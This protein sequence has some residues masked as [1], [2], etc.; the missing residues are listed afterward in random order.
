MVPYIAGS[1][2]PSHPSRGTWKPAC[3]ACDPSGAWLPPDVRT[4][5][6]PA[7]R[8]AHIYGSGFAVSSC[9]GD[10][11]GPATRKTRRISGP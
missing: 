2:F 5:P 8:L 4:A 6:N 9:D 11:C 1:V 7:H 10:V 3:G